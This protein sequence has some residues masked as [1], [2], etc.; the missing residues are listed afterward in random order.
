MAKDKPLG[1]SPFDI[2][3]VN[4]VFG[5]SYP[6]PYGE[7]GYMLSS[8]WGKL[9]ERVFRPRFLSA[10]GRGLVG[11]ISWSEMGLDRRLRKVY[12]QPRGVQAIRDLGVINAGNNAD[13]YHYYKTFNP[14]T[15]YAKNPELLD[16]F[17]SGPKIGFKPKRRPT[18]NQLASKKWRQA[19]GLEIS[20]EEVKNRKLLRYI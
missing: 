6:M 18:P 12:E 8:M 16:Q 7:L 3:M 20:P 17:V 5:S 11:F 1:L 10:C 4:M 14:Y 15:D 19:N 2:D 13:M 9:P